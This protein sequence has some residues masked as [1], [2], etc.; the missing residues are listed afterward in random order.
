MIKA[1]FLGSPSRRRMSALAGAAALFSLSNT[2]LD[3]IAPLWATSDLGLDAAGWAHLRGL[4]MAGTTGGILV[5]GLAAEFF[6]ARR[7]AMLSLGGA[8]VL[9]AALAG[10]GAE[11]AFWLLPL[12]GALVSTTYV[13]LNVLTQHVSERKQGIA[14]GIYR[15]VSQ[16]MVIVAP[17]LATTLGTAAGSY[18][19]VLAIGS[20]LLGVAALTVLSYHLPTV[21]RHS[22][23]REL[24]AGLFAAF[25]HR[26]L[27]S[28]ILIDQLMAF[29]MGPV[30]AFGALRL[31]RELGLSELNFGVGVCTAAGGLGLVSILISGWLAERMSL[32]ILMGVPWLLCAVATLTLGLTDSLPLSIVAVVVAGAGWAVPPVPG[33]I[34]LAQVTGKTPTGLAV[35]KMVQSLT[36][37]CSMVLAGWLEPQWGMKAVLV[38][39]GCL[40][41]PIAVWMLCVRDPRGRV[42]GPGQ[43]RG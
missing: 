34:W 6:G 43:T 20:L 42:Q 28:Y 24:F 22:S 3:Q 15:G 11:R 7:M 1:L 9:L 12:F 21:H 26:P 13:N 31:T 38:G 27:W 33:S 36:G 17:A 37:A 30:V 25:L 39:A 18:V 41:L 14:N 10:G 2:A 19:P 35:H 16:G 23:A 8:G 29:T 40:G 4:R 5:L 32:S